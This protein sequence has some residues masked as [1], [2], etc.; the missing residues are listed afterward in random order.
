MVNRVNVWLLRIIVTFMFIGVALVYSSRAEA[1]PILSDDFNPT[2]TE[3]NPAW[4]FYDP[5][6]TTAGNDPGQSTLTF[7]GTNA[8]IEIP[9]GVSHDLWVGSGNRAPRLLQPVANG[10]F[11][12]EVKF[13]SKPATRSQDQGIIVQQ[14]NAT[15][16]RFDTY[17]DGF[18]PRVFVAYVA[19]STK[20][21]FKN[22]TLPSIPPYLRVLRT[23]NTWTY[24]YSYD[25]TTWTDAVTF[26]QA[27]TVTE[28]GVFG[29]TSSE[30]PH[31]LASIDYFMDLA[32]PIADTDV[33]VPPPPPPPS[34]DVWYG[35]TKTFGQLGNPQKWINILG[36][37]TSSVGVN[38]LTYSLNGGPDKALAIGPD[39]F[40]LH[41]PGD[42]NIE[43]HHA[44]LLNGANTVEINAMDNWGIVTTDMVTVNYTPGNVW[45]FPYTA[46]WGT[47]TN[48]QEVEQIAQIV[49]GFWQLTPAGIRPAPTG[50]DRAIAIGDETWFTDYEVT[51]PITA[52]S[53]FTGMGV[54][55]GWQGHEGNQSPKIEWPLQALAWV[56]GGSPSKL[57]IVTYGGLPTSSWEVVRATQSVV[58]TGNVAYMLKTRSEFLGG[59]MSRVYV[60]FWPKSDS[61]PNQWNIN[62]D[63]P[64][65]DGSVLL[66]SYNA[67]VTFGNVE[68]TP[69]LDPPP[70]TPPSIT[71]QPADR[72]V[73]AGQTAT[74]SVTASGSAPLAYQWQKN[75]VNITGATSASYTTPATTSADNGATF[76]CIVSNSV[77]STTSNSA[78][79]TVTAGTSS[80][81]SDDFNT[82]TTEP[83]P[84]WRFY[85]PYSGVTG[86]STLTYNGTNALIA[87]PAGLSHDLWVGSANRAPR[88]LQPAN[89]GDF[90]IEAKFESSPA[91]RYQMQGIV[92][93][94]DNATFLRFD[95]HHDGTSP[96]VFVAYVAGNTYQ[97]YR[98]ATLPSI[99][100]YRQVLR[101]GN[102]WTC[103]YSY[104]ATTWTDAVTFTRALTVTEV[105]VFGGTHTPNPAFVASMDY[106]MNLAAPIV[107]ND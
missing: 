86:Q 44:S 99:P 8:L 1:A 22:A 83:N 51:V 43:I 74:F 16:L 30:N 90:G 79:L 40:R 38:S 27:L 63:V 42:F 50:Y 62:A 87:I 89:N 53:S 12:I 71:S 105:G 60:K 75:G 9:A 76:R 47:L 39:G 46:D 64:T 24:R 25:G 92:V 91:T 18:G 23:G 7:D 2:T 72:T 95:T 21:I 3:P 80:L 103:R 84:S 31:F 17:H 36:N 28:V 68:I 101:A 19:G 37:A 11:G 65:R 67:N 10:D 69:V 49:D 52:P 73:T 4:R 93:Q 82:T 5:Y 54:A 104:D 48:I 85:D 81:L 70:P 58:V 98:N 96:R 100:P 6:D 33:W 78:T 26:T 102:Q 77:G 56:R 45:P 107:D 57:Q 94:Q 55:I 32:A 15:F 59:G 34:I 14:N 41:L 88:L 29:G 35:N 106:F 97:V 13:E 20:T 66:V 61:E